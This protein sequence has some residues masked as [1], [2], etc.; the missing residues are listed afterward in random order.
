MK[1]L[2][3]ADGSEYTRKAARAL[4]KHVAA[5]REAP[6]IRVHHVIPPIPYPGAASVVGKKAID[7]Y[8]R[9]SA[10]TALKVATKEFARARLAYTAAWSVGEVAAEIAAAV[11]KNRVDLVVV[12][13]RGHGALA[14]LALGSVALKLLATLAVPV[15]IVR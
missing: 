14:G 11:K 4:I 6:E 8:H 3:A 15:L 7:D 10:E 1:I 5:Y 9:E 13:S 2:L 12:G